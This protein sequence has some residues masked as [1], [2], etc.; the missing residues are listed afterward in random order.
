[1][2]SFTIATLALLLAS[3]A[4]ARET[5][6]WRMARGLPPMAP[7]RRDADYYQ[8]PRKSLTPFTCTPQQNFCCQG[9]VPADSPQ[10]YEVL[11]DYGITGDTC[12]ETI[13]TGCSAAPS[14]GCP[15]GTSEA[16]C[17]GTMAGG[18]YAVDCKPY[19]YATMGPR[20]PIETLL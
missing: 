9:Y 3:E 13:G 12:G 11:N 18:S 2:K 15:S 17:C 8:P 7:R 14:T 4:A 20:A 1:M 19:S 6:A 16:T 5:N 10:G